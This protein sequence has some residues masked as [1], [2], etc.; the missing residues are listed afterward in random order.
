MNYASKGMK[1]DMRSRRGLGASEEC[2]LMEKDMK[3]WRDS[4]RYANRVTYILGM[5]VDGGFDRRCG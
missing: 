3:T 4:M 2:S 5:R 1:N